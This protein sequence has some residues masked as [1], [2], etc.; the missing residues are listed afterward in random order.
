MLTIQEIDD[1]LIRYADTMSLNALSFK[2]EGA[3]TPEQCGARLAQLL[4]SPD[5]LTAV[6]QDQLVTMKMRRLIVELEDMPRTTRNAEVLFGGLDKLGARLDKRAAATELEL[7][8]LYA[9]Q[10]MVLL[11]GVNAAMSHI[12]GQIAAGS[13]PKTELEWDRMLENAIRFAQLEISQHEKTSAPESAPAA[14][15]EVV[16]PT[17]LVK[18]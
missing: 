8:T 12:R 5:W 18:R 11:D 2:I 15:Y 4:D 7:S 3:L 14:E 9:F 6:Q 1:A 17:G 10:G 13:I 16:D